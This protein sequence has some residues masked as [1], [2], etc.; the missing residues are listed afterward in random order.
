LVLKAAPAQGGAAVEQIPQNVQFLLFGFGPQMH[1]TMALVA[2]LL[3]LVMTIL[4][5][6]ST[7]RASPLGLSTTNWF[8]LAIILFVFGLTFWFGAYFGAKEGFRG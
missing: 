1:A 3:G 4:G 5:I 7:V 2:N 8:L 6:I